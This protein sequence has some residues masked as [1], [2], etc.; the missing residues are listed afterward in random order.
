MAINTELLNSLEDSQLVNAIG[1]LYNLGD[2]ATPMLAEHLEEMQDVQDRTQALIEATKDLYKAYQ[3]VSAQLKAQKDANVKLMY[4]ATKRG[5]KSKT[6]EQSE[7]EKADR[8]L[9]DAL[10]SIE[11]ESEDD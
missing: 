11:L 10:G 7:I 4:D 3:D 9:D 1:E 6:D 2:D 5:L 8:E